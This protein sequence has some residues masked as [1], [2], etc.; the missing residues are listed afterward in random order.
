MLAGSKPRPRLPEPLTP[1]AELPAQGRGGEGKAPG[2]GP[3]PGPRPWPAPLPRG[4][5]R[6]FISKSFSSFFVF[7]RPAPLSSSADKIRPR[8]WR[9]G[10]RADSWRAVSGTGRAESWVVGAENGGSRPADSR[11]RAVLGSMRSAPHP[12]EIPEVLGRPEGAVSGA[13]GGGIGAPPG[14]EVGGR[15]LGT[16]ALLGRPSLLRRSGPQRPAVLRQLAAPLSRVSCA[17][18]GST[19]VSGW[20]SLGTALGTW[21]RSTRR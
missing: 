8:A 16:E 9:P 10:C 21:V 12:W 20:P 11:A 5:L 18:L 17:V 15:G 6:V 2:E 3:C 7:R 4:T 14:S 1:T 19:G 13:G